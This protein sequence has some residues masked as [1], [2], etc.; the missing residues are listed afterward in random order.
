M[1]LEHGLLN[2]TTYFYSYFYF[3]ESLSHAYSS[4][5]IR[6]NDSNNYDYSMA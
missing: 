4:Y 1:I 5:L 3:Y 2:L 6:E